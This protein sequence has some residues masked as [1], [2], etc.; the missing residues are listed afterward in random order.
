MNRQY[1]FSIIVLILFLVTV[2]SLNAQD[3]IN[4]NEALDSQE[5]IEAD[6]EV[7][8]ENE[9]ALEEVIDNT[10]KSDTNA[11]LSNNENEDPS[12]ITIVHALKTTYMQDEENN[13]DMI[14]FEGDVIVSVE[15]GNSTTTIY[16]DLIDF[17]R[18]RNS[19]FAVGSVSMEQSTNGTV[20]ERLTSE[21]LLFNTTTLEGYFNEGRVIQ[22]DQESLSLEEGSFLIVSSELFSKGASNTVTF[23]NG[24]LTFC[25]DENPHWEIKASRIWLLPGNEFAFANALLFVGPVPVMYFPFF[26]YPKDELV[27]NPAFGFRS[28]EGFFMQTTTYL[29]GRKP[30]NTSSDD[31]EN[32]IGFNFMQQNQLKEQELQGLILRNLDEN[33]SATTDYLKIIGDYYTTLGGLVGIQGYFEP[34]TAF[35][36]ISFDARLGFSNVVFNVD[37]FP[38]YVSYENNQKFADYGWFFGNKLPFRY[39]AVFSTDI[40]FDSFTMSIEM[41]FF[42]DPWF[43]DDFNDRQE[44][45]DWIDFF[46]SGELTTPATE[47][48]DDED[49]I[50]GFTWDITAS[51]KPSIPF[52][53]PWITDISLNTI[54]SAVVFTTQREDSN[55]FY[56]TNVY[57]NSPNREFFYPSQIKPLTLKSSLSGTLVD[58]STEEK[59]TTYSN[60]NTE[61][62]SEQKDVIATMQSPS[63][64]SK[65]DTV[66]ND[67]D[68]LNNTNENEIQREYLLSNETLPLAKITSI[69]TKESIQSSYSLTYDIDPEL[70]TLY[71]YSGTKPHSQIPISPSDF[72]ITNPK[73]GQFTFKS[74]ITINS[75]LQLYSSLVT[76]TNSLSFL[77]EHQNH[78]ILSSEYHTESE[79]ES[80]IIGDYGAHQLD[81][82]NTNKLTVKPFLENEIFSNSSINWNT[83]VSLITTDFTGTYQQPKWDYVK[84]TWDEDSITTHN[85][86][87]VLEARQED[88]YQR[89][90]LETNLP[91]QVDQY[92]GKLDFGFPVGSLSFSSG[93]KQVSSLL[94]NWEFQPFSQSATFKFFE[95]TD[96]NTLTMSQAY[97]Y[98]IEDSHSETLTTSLSW[99]GLKL[100]YDMRHEYSYTLDIDKG[101][102]ASSEESFLPYS[103]SLQWNIS[104]YQIKS[105]DDSIIIK[106]A[107]STNVT[108]DM[109]IPTRSYLSFKPS[110]SLEISNFLSLT[111][112]AES[113][114]EQLVKYF[115]DI[116]G[117]TPE[118]PGEQ[119]IFIDLFNSFAFF[120]EEKRQS[121]GFKIES[122]NIA[123]EH[124]LH[125]W[126]LTSEFEIE[127]R[128]ITESNGDKKFDYSPYFTLSVLWKPMSSL[129]TTIEDDYGEFTLNP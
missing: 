22:E 92:T 125:D 30:L 52:L 56:N 93:Y 119:N 25:N 118:I 87:A 79:K 110:L 69:T 42:S 11:D 61:I 14:R 85:L 48:D 8:I 108:L 60:S 46:L 35:R 117:F 15:K 18:K 26:Y 99:R 6:N 10:E 96:N 43:N 29:I 28:R 97:K 128:I 19:L 115:Q 103:T 104:N 112:S 76:V 13:T 111:F 21:S 95:N 31:T 1:R 41:P 37:N 24:N 102:I 17:D 59:P 50:T 83:A 127:P 7:T 23:K 5:I 55:D 126:I 73:S 107:L 113:R 80:I 63:T 20:T 54:N 32:D 62:T 94:D 27:F 64:V 70:S 16:S 90:T 84:A 36:N 9:T 4:E 78:Y 67:E 124:D 120:D 71:A 88:F 77:P 49:K 123:L 101:W 66:E 40:S 75:N 12:I 2:L 53:E 57:T 106:P 109:I 47:T 45:M 33:A 51:Y 82:K 34:N 58:W 89:L 98:N 3:A 129:K 38:L 72:D 105:S 39:G 122:F 68:A 91:P 116:I 100:A 81:V 65:D 121:S 74:P 114:N 44:S 86:N